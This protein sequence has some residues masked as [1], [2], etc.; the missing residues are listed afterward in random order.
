MTAPL[1]S[2]R[3]KVGMGEDSLREFRANGQLIFPGYLLRQEHASD[4]AL[5]KGKLS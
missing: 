2:L 5:P 1:P 4:D 3:E